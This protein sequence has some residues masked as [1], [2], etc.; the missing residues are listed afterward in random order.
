MRKK[1]GERE[2]FSF[3]DEP[4]PAETVTDQPQALL[5]WIIRFWTKPSITLRDIHRSGPHFLRDKETILTLAQ[6]LVERGWFVPQE[7]WRRD[8]HEWKIARG[9]PLGK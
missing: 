5:D 7:T 8:K 6:S 1:N 3:A 4:A 9:L 2:T